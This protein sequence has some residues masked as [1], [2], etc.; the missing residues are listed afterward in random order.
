MQ[1]RLQGYSD[2]KTPNCIFHLN[3]NFGVRN[4]SGFL[5]LL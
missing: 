4:E 1:S 5:A 3:R 2:A